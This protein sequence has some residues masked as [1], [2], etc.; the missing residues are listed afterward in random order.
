[1]K[2]KFDPVQMVREIRDDL[3]KQTKRMTTRERIEYYHQQA[4]EFYI[5]LGVKEPLIKAR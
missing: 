3:Y 5:R 2:K 1:M 4:K